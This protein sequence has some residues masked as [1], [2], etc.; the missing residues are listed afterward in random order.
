MERNE[1]HIEQ[2][3]NAVQCIINTDA[4]A[5]KVFLGLAIIAFAIYE[6]SQD[7][8]GTLRGGN[9]SADPNTPALEP[10]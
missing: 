2:V 7:N 1:G 6:T 9:S 5:W 3:A 10:A 4:K 8:R